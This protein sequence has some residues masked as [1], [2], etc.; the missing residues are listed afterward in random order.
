[1]SSRTRNKGTVTPWISSNMT[2]KLMR[3]FP[4]SLGIEAVDYK[5]V[6]GS[7]TVAVQAPIVNKYRRTPLFV[8]TFLIVV[9]SFSEPSTISYHPA[10]SS[11]TSVVP[12]RSRNQ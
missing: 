2:K 4:A 3:K 9:P 1:M 7:H 10:A 11:T 8:F 5:Y 12:S 6:G